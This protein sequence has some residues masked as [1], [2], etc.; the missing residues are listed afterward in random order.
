MGSRKKLLI[1][2]AKNPEE[3]YNPQSALGSYIFCLSSI[4]H[5]GYF[6]VHV[7]GDFIESN[8]KRDEVKLKNPLKN[9]S[10]SL[11]RL[12]PEIIKSSIKDLVL[13]YRI[14]KLYKKIDQE[15]KYDLILEMCSYG[16]N[17]GY[18]LAEKHNTPFFSIF[19]SPAKE[20]YVYFH[21]GA[22]VFSY[23]I[24][25]REG[26]T[27]K[28]SQKIV[29]YSPIVKS[30][31]IEKYNLKD[32]LFYFHQNVDFERF[33]IVEKHDANENVVF[34]FIGSFLKWHKVDHLVESFIK[35]RQSGAK[36]R[37]IL[38]GYGL[39]FMNIKQLVENSPYKDDIE[40]PGFVDGEVLK[41]YKKTIDVGILSGT[42]WYCAPNK[43][44]EYGA[45]NMAVIAQYTDTINYL[46]EDGKEIML[47]N[48]ESE[49]DLLEAMKVCVSSRNKLDLLK[50]NLHYKVLNT[51]SKENSLRFY[52]DLLN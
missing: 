46:F 49:N 45:A 19:D 5:E 29:V 13:F 43:L 14:K 28:S 10:F 20:E 42:T 31:L 15:Y 48:S 26:L 4:L 35:L 33:D 17:I 22:S 38:L 30:Y 44:F 51:Y 21:G 2:Y 11:K 3:V 32:T 41:K 52:L 16:S 7:N 23:W 50:K 6:D 37:L 27:L 8:S 12:F 25:R 24:D 39:E 1:I 36:A 47:F 34:G 18:K 9:S 40:L